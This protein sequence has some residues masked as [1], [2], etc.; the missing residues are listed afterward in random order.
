MKWEPI[1]KIPPN[2]LLL[3]RDEFYHIGYAYPTYFPFKIIPDPLGRK[4]H[5][6]IEYC[7][8]Y[9]DGGWL[10]QEDFRDLGSIKVKIK[11]WKE[12]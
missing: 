7:D 12:L 4:W 5:S 8:E 6:T 11:Q 2:K 10:I 3:I 9:W 1:S